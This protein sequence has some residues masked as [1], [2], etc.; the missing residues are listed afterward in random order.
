MYREIEFVGISSEVR[1]WVDG[2]GDSFF[3]FGCFLFE[4]ENKL[5]LVIRI[6]YYF[7][8][9]CYYIDSN[10]DKCILL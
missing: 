8:W 3:N 9:I 4:N 7:N 6:I 2:W 1:G 5:I 10:N